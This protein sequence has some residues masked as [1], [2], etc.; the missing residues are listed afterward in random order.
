MSNTLIRFLTCAAIAFMTGCAQYVTL[1]VAS[2]PAGAYITEI[3]TK[4]ALGISPIFARYLFTNLEKHKNDQGCYKVSGFEAKWVSGAISRTD[5]L[6]FCRGYAR[7][8]RTLIKRNPEHPGF[9]KDLQF[10]VQ[11]QILNAQKAQTQ[12][13]KDAAQAAM[14]QSV[15]SEK[16]NDAS[17]ISTPVGDSVYTRCK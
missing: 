13:Q 17:C 2:E 4:R 7:K 1:E 14:W 15:F 12:A 9:E 8:Y 11:V 5:K 16:K 3:G 10:S 6:L